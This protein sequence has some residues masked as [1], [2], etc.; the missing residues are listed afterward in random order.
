MAVVRFLWVGAELAIAACDLAEVIGT[1]IALQL[2]FGLPLYAGVLITAADVLLLLAVAGRSARGL[3]A[4]ILALLLVICACFVFTL[5]KAAPPAVE[6]LAGFL[7]QK[8]IFTNASE[9]Y[10]AAGILGATVMP[11]NLYL[12]SALVQSR[13][14]SKDGPGR[15]EA[16]A[17]ATVDST[18]SLIIAGFVNCA[19]L[20]V[21]ADAFAGRA[22]EMA[23]LHDAAA[24]LAPALGAQRRPKPLPGVAEHAD[25]HP[26][27]LAE[28]NCC[29]PA[30]GLAG[31][32]A[33]AAD[34]APTVTWVS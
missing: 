2:L 4:L 22:A 18:T 24:L 25:G 9:L 19:I 20:I 1:A 34:E 28:A 10:I 11:H 32:A 23:T 17:Y 33:S 15:R 26:G 6:V 3:E 16:I 5:A 7:S 30:E 31:R 14:F 21:A 8:R 29:S 12:H 27:G 13:G